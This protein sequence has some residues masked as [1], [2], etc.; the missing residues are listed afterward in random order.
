VRLM[1]Y[2]S[3]IKENKIIQLIA[4]T[5]ADICGR[6][7]LSDSIGGST[8]NTMRSGRRVAGECIIFLLLFCDV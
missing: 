7:S 4:E 6:R 2:L 1:L 5:A 8:G 3:N